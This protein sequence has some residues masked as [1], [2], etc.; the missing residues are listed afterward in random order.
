MEPS[1]A[2]NTCWWA[3]VPVAVLVFVVYLIWQLRDSRSTQLALASVTL[4][5]V[6]LAFCP[7]APLAIYLG[8]RAMAG[9]SGPD[10]R[11][12]FMSWA[13]IILGTIGCLFLAFVSFM[14]SI[15]LYGYVTGRYP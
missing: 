5:I 4:G 10:S 7:L 15:Y 8:R 3:V 14:A 6:G 2:W 1:A 9:G 13:G 12:T 11:V